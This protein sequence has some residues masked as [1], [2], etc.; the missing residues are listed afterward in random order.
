M[1]GKSLYIKY[2]KAHGKV[3][4]PSP[5]PAMHGDTMEHLPDFDDLTAQQQKGWNAADKAPAKKK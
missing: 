5:H 3:C 2:R 4:V 1:S